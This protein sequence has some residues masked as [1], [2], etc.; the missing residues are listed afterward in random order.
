MFDTIGLILA[1]LGSLVAWSSL[2]SLAAFIV[3]LSIIVFV[4]EFGHFIVGRWCGVGVREFSIG[5][6]R[7]LFGWTDRRGTRWKVCLLP[8]GGYVRFIGDLTAA[9][10]PDN[11]ELDGLTPEERAISFPR[12]SVGK[13]AAIIAAGPLANFLLAI[14]IFAGFFMTYGKTV[15]EPRIDEVIVGGRAEE[16]ALRA[17]DL[18]LSINGSKVVSFPEVVQHIT[19]SPDKPL[20]IKILRDGSEV[21]LTA[22]PK[23][24]W[25]TTPVGS[26]EAGQLG[27]KVDARLPERWHRVSFSPIGA[28]VEGIRET[29]TIIGQSLTTISK[30]VTGQVSLKQLSGPVGIGQMTGHVAGL[31]LLALVGY[32]AFLSVSI[33][34]VNLLPVP[35]LDGGHLVFCAI[36]AIRRQ[37][38]N[39]RAQDIAFRLGFALILTLIVVVSWN[40]LARIFASPPSM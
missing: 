11:E 2:F 4:H 19:L 22:T 36:E 1:K 24:E 34:M 16:A 33:G 35:V 30:L 25:V 20:Q 15:L 14:V 7:E 18:I 38:L 26:V 40:D 9:S 23:L 10:M 12:Q 5:F 6:G 39:E 21:A 28:V 31:G 32:V 3:V 37:P 13:R 8:L 27:F 29:G 17:G